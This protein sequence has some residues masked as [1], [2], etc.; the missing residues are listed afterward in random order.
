MF[1]ASRGKLAIGLVIAI[2][3]VAGGVVMVASGS[4]FGWFAVIFVPFVVLLVRQ[5][6][7][8]GFVR[9]TGATLEVRQLVGATRTYD[10]ALCSEFVAYK[11]GQGNRAVGF[12][13]FGDKGERSWF[14]RRASKYSDTI[15]N[16]YDA[17]P[18]DLADALNAARERAF[19]HPSTGE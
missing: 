18:E 5:L 1:R 14:D 3:G 8:P 12:D 4:L 10:L 19:D 7:R 13:Y 15:T 16:L 2:G 17:P 11:S 6:F 9:I